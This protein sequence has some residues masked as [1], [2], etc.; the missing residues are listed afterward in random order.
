M[1]H[2]AALEALAG[3]ISGDA[4]AD[5]RGALEGLAAE[6]LDAAG[7]AALVSDSSRTPRARAA[8]ATKLQTLGSDEEGYGGEA[9]IPVAPHVDALLAA[10]K[11][12]EC[13]RG[14]RAESKP[15]GFATAFKTTSPACRRCKN[16]LLL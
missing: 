11:D 16:G 15:V 7:L 14:A 1:L 9:A 3:E 10:V 4:V 6:G 13:P 12:P 8:G 5:V 2:K